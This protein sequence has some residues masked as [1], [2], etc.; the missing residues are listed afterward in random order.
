MGKKKVI[1]ETGPEGQRG[2]ALATAAALV[3]LEC[4][5]HMGVVDI[6]KKSIRTSLA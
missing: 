4:E 2:V 5:I 1:A 6:A 3:G